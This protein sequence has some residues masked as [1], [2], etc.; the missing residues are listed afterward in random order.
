MEIFQRS[1]AQSEFWKIVETKE[2]DMEI[3]I[4]VFA[5]IAI[6]GFLVWRKVAGGSSNT[7][8]SSA[9]YGACRVLEKGCGDGT[10][11]R[12]G[13]TMTLRLPGGAK[14]EMVWCPPGSFMMGSPAD[15]AG[16]QDSET[17]HRV[18]L[19]EGFWMAKYAVT[20]KQWK[21]VMGNNPS[22][23]K[24]RALPVEHVSWHDC[25]EFC[26]KTGMS[27]PTEAQWEYAC[28]AGSTGPYGGKGD[29]KAMGWQCDIDGFH[30]TQPVGKKAPNAW[31]LYDM[32]GNVW[33]WCMD[34]WDAKKPS[35][36]LFDP[37]SADPYDQCVIRGG[38][39]IW[40]NPDGCRSASR[41]YEKPDFGEQ[42]FGT[43]IELIGF[44]PVA[45]AN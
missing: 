14:M 44:R 32:H 2:H 22:Y 37:R 34:V 26:K 3:I 21:S 24:G 15:E 13:T 42:A 33:E 38:S 12:A 43:P 45:R 8:H 6:P 30:S 7:S 27:L 41:S 17:L 39:I 10:D 35:G 40:T 11:R 16:H 29:L 25:M 18:T 19:E 4:I 1:N 9:G 5:I 23:F 36:V 28:R 31:G 20:Q